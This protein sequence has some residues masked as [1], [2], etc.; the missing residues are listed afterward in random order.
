MSDTSILLKDINDVFE[1]ASNWANLVDD[2]LKVRFVAKRIKFEEVTN[3]RRDLRYCYLL[4]T[5]DGLS[6]FYF[7]NTAPITSETRKFVSHCDR[8][9]ALVGILDLVRHKLSKMPPP[10][11]QTD[12]TPSAAAICIA[13]VSLETRSCAPERTYTNCER[14]VRLVQ[15]TKG[16]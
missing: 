9:W 16:T 3:Y 4:N 10:S 6:L 2:V 14:F 5:G 13:D 8:E 15:F 7:V 12:L 1:S 11:R